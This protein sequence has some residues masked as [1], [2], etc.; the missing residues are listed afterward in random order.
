MPGGLALTKRVVWSDSVRD[1]VESG[2]SRFTQRAS[3]QTTSAAGLQALLDVAARD[4]PD[5]VVLS[6]DDGRVPA[7]EAC[8]RLRSDPRTSGI[9]I[10]VLRSDGADAEP[11]RR[12]GCN[13]VIPE[14]IGARALQEKIAGALGLRLRRHPRFPVVLPVARGRL[15]HEFLGYS[16]SLSESGMGFD[17]LARI[18]GGDQLN[19][20]IYR[21]TEEDPIRVT[22]RVCAVRPNIDTGAGYTAGVEF[23][24]LAAGDK[25]RLMALFPTDGCVTWG[26]DA[27]EP[28]PDES[29]G[30]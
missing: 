22:A 13:E 21:S 24:R 20:K 30:A 16:N 10:L 25:D 2:P 29:G 5:L 8:E 11:L 9:P 26:S 15:F 7:A 18:R 28:T 4:R 3:L 6:L 19:L 27:P 12:A 14:S 17:T 23:T 1:R